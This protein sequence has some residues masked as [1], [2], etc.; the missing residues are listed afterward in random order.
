MTIR[1]FFWLDS[2]ANVHSAY[3]DTT[4][5]DEIGIPDSEWNE[6]TEDQ[7]DE[8]MRKLAWERFDWGWR[9]VD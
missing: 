7:K 4:S 2:G 9:E 1:I 3:K 8:V 5:T 6:M